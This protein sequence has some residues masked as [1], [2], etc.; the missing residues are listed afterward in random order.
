MSS[1]TV[2]MEAYAFRELVAHLQWRNDVQNIDLMNL[3]G[4]CRNCLAKWYHAGS[5]VY[6]LPLDYDQSCERI[7][8]EPY[9]DWK[10]KYQKKASQDQMALFESGKAGHAKTEPKLGEAGQAVPMATPSG[11]SNVCGQS[12]D[13]EPAAPIPMETDGAFIEARIGVLTASDRASEGVYPD[14]S[15]PAIV[16]AVKSF[17]ERSGSFSPRFTQ[18]K[19]VPDDKDQIYS[20]LDSW[21]EGGDCDLIFTTGGT[22]FGPRDVTPEATRPLIERPA[23]GLARAMAWQTSFVEPHSILSRGI[24]GITKRQVII[25]NLPGNPNAV[26]QCLSVLLPVLPHALRMVSTRLHDHKVQS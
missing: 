13:D 20:S 25:V 4:F 7:Y 1:L 6:G 21:S 11:H 10:K 19:I 9:G 18:Q 22:G 17:A 8:G 14:E 2:Q 23:D 24:C 5:K 3:S 16:A 15:G 26:K 12:C